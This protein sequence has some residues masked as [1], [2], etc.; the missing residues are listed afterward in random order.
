MVIED[1]GDYISEV[2]LQEDQVYGEPFD[3][4]EVHSDPIPPNVVEVNLDDSNGDLTMGD[5]VAFM[6]TTKTQSSPGNGRKRNAM[7]NEPIEELYKHL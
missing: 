3:E 4:E 6:A 2:G 5:I 1:N 7:S